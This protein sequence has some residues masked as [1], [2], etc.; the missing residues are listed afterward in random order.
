MLIVNIVDYRRCYAKRFTFWMV[1][2]IGIIHK[3]LF[4]VLK[5]AGGDDLVEQVTESVGI[6]SDE[7]RISETY[8]DEEFAQ[9]F[10]S[11]LQITQL[12]RA[13]VIDLY[14]DAF[15]GYAQE[16]FPA[17]F[18]MSDSAYD[19]LRRQPKIHTSLSASLAC[20]EE[21]EKVEQKFLLV[22][23]SDGSLNLSYFSKVG[24]C[25]LYHALAHKIAEHYGDEIT[26]SAETCGGGKQCSLRLYFNNPPAN[27]MLSSCLLG[28]GR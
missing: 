13:Q 20:D 26:I 7:V 8:P 9:L 16:L 28:Y 18:A 1:V 10:A 2:M 12:P 23:E 27:A 4:D 21:R 15:L 6:N 5:Q 25:D 17:F 19:F 22:E 24:L 14:A 3:V 11:A